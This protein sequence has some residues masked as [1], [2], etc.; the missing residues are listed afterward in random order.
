MSTIAFILARKNSMRIKNKHNLKIRNLNLVE[1]TIEFA[2]K[3]Q[4][5]KKIVLSTNDES[6]LN[7]DY[8]SKL[9]KIKRPEKLSKS[10]STTASA[11]I[12]A[13]N[14]LKKKK[15][16]FKNVILLQPTTPFRSKSM[17]SDAFKIFKKNKFIYPLISVS[18]TSRMKKRN[19]EIKNGFLS[20]SKKNKENY[21]V[22]GNF[23][24]SNKKFIV[25]NKTFF[26]DK[27]TIAFK[28]QNPKYSI[29]IDT[30]Q[31]YKLALN[32]I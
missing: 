27:K 28:I 7:K 19:F 26:K 29:D 10:N 15:I 20:L 2:Y 9:V 13:F 8:K 22:N 1:N 18:K 24:F 32:F 3:L 25:K 11:L 4:F 17:V 14:F 16:S 30:I 31:D 23:F 5:I 21:Q 12:H 6:F